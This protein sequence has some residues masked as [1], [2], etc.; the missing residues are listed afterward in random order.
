MRRI[1]TG[2]AHPERVSRRLSRR[3]RWTSRA[4]W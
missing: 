1:A 2:Q 3:L 4:R